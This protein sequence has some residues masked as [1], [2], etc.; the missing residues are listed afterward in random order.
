MFS[1][2]NLS[3][4]DKYCVFNT[5]IVPALVTGESFKQITQTNRYILFT[6]KFSTDA[7]TTEGV[8]DLDGL[9]KK[10]EEANG[11]DNFNVLTAQLGI[12]SGGGII[13]ANKK[14]NIYICVFQYAPRNS[15]HP[16]MYQFEST[17][18]TTC[19][20]DL[21]CD[22]APTTSVYNRWFSN[23]YVKSLI[24][25]DSIGTQT[26]F[27]DEVPENYILVTIIN[28]CADTEKMLY[29]NF[30]DYYMDMCKALVPVD[31]RDLIKSEYAKGSM[32]LINVVNYLNNY[33]LIAHVNKSSKDKYTFTF[34]SSPNDYSL[35]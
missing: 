13:N 14:N 22:I 35:D 23:K 17:F 5:Y 6:Y 20:S 10:F 27:F 1:N 9:R 11:L 24:E 30:D 21:Y 25:W 32:Y 8:F 19:K 33:F 29:K 2:D 12:T 7:F 34:V 31:M 15:F 16:S 28:M 18:P 26:K 3:E 4:I